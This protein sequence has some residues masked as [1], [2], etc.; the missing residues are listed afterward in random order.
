MIGYVYTYLS[1]HQVKTINGSE[2]VILDGGNYIGF[3]SEIYSRSC[4]RALH[5]SERSRASHRSREPGVDFHDAQLA[6]VSN[7]GTTTLRVE[8]GRD[9][10]SA[11]WVQPTSSRRD[12]L[13]VFFC[14]YGPTPPHHAKLALGN[15][16]DSFKRSSHGLWKLHVERAC[17][18]RP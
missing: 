2:T 14:L 15:D 3:T 5:A 13:P 6:D 8:T 1:Y 17:T 16:H 11:N 12:L 7:V 18:L 9:M 10:I 4:S